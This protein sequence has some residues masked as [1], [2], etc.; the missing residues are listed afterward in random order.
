MNRVQKQYVQEILDD[1]LNDQEAPFGMALECER[2]R[3]TLFALLYNQLSS[4]YEI[5]MEDEN[6]EQF[7]GRN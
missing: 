2:T 1:R 5:D 4:T 7:V 3:V 6:V